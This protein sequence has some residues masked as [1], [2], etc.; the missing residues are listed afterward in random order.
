MDQ[1]APQASI[2]DMHLQA[3]TH[4]LDSLSLFG[5]LQGINQGK[6]LVSLGF[7]LFCLGHVVP[8][9]QGVHLLEDL[10]H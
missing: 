8:H 3:M 9:E 4:F 6:R 5:C 2:V 7:P 1:G 10:A